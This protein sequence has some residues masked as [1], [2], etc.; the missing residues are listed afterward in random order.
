MNIFKETTYENKMIKVLIE[1][2]ANYKKKLWNFNET[3]KIIFQ[4]NLC[5]LANK[6]YSVFEETAL[7]MDTDMD[8]IEYTVTKLKLLE[9]KNDLL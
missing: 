6:M 8:Q 9:E 1:L 3:Q 5:D 2:N 4:C 7:E